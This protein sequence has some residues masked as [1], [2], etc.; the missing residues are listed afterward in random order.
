MAEAG[1]NR[2]MV[3]AML[4]CGNNAAQRWWTAQQK[5]PD[6]APYRRET[7]APGMYLGFNLKKMA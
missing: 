4:H 5:P 6:G 1:R 2:F 7:L 3:L